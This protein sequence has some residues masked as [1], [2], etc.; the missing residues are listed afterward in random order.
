MQLPFADRS[1]DFVIDVM[2]HQHTTLVDYQ[3]AVSEVS[4]VLKSDGYFYTYRF[5]DKTDPH[6]PLLQSGDF[7]LPDKRTVANVFTQCGLAIRDWEIVT[8]AGIAPAPTTYVSYHS[9]IAQ[10]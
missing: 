6:N 8:R 9:I 4:R 3:K 5:A 1:F 7:S 10:K 2:N